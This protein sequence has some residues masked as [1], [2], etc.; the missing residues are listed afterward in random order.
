MLLSWDLQR[1][2][3][4]VNNTVEQV[5]VD[6]LGEGISGVYCLVFGYWL[7]HCL[8]HQNNPPMAQPTHQ[9]PCTHT[10]QLTEDCQMGI[11][12]LKDIQIVC[13]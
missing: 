5:G 2:V 9:P 6:L 4:P 1:C 10:Q 8:S 13:S 3:Y 11:T 7:H 12:G